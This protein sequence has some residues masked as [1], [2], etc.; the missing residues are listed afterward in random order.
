MS[1]VLAKLKYARLSA[2]K[3]R[4]VANQIR[5]M[6]VDKALTLLTFSPKKAAGLLKKVLE[7]AI[8]NAE[9]NAG[10]DIDELKISKLLVDEAP[11]FKR[12]QAR[13]KGRGNQIVKRSC[14]IHIELQAA[15]SK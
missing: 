3:A 13:A 4:L 2:Q 5:G 8:A 11:S 9:H 7:S 10:L 14:H 15:S 1:S 12:F 6:S